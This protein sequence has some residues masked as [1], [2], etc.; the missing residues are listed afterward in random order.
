MVGAVNKRQEPSAGFAAGQRVPR[1]PAAKPALDERGF[2]CRDMAE[3]GLRVCGPRQRVRHM[4]GKCKA[5][6]GRR[7]RQLW[8][9]IVHGP[10]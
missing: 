5:V 7:L 10:R 2:F 1:W 4:R 8:G 6:N 9:L 3:D